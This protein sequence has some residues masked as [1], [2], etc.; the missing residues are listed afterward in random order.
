MQ[1]ALAMCIPFARRV[2]ASLPSA[3]AGMSRS[4]ME[5]MEAP[6][7]SPS[8]RCAGGRVAA[9]ASHLCFSSPPPLFLCVRRSEILASLAR[10]S[11][12]IAEERPC[13]GMKHSR[14]KPRSSAD[15]AHERT[16][17]CQNMVRWRDRS[18]AVSTLSRRAAARSPRRGARRR[19]ARLGFAPGR[20][21]AACHRHSKV[22]SPCG[23]CLF[24][25]AV[26][27]AAV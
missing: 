17:S 22:G 24:A 5:A 2:W 1:L 26:L 16:S 12:G 14:S 4:A 23:R 6:R 19:H 3:S 10:K 15:P 27:L 11:D 13:C 18:P 9:F 21:R 25:S 8:P 7:P 20:L